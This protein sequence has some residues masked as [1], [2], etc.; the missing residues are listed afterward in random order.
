MTAR[1]IIKFIA[2]IILAGCSRDEEVI[3]IVEPTP[4]PVEVVEISQGL[5]FLVLDGN[6]PKADRVSYMIKDLEGG[7]FHNGHSIKLSGHSSAIYLDEGHYT[8]YNLKLL[9]SGLEIPFSAFIVLEYRKRPVKSTSIIQINPDRI[10]TI[11]L[12]PNL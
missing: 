9:A 6:K 4:D 7:D 2:I 10:T 8:L 11:F 1:Q 12:E 3:P 5:N